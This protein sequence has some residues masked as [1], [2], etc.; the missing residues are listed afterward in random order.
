MT[1]VLTCGTSDSYSLFQIYKQR[2]QL[3]RF[4]P[5]VFHQFTAHL[6]HLPP[7]LCA[8]PLL[9]LV[10]QRSIGLPVPP[11]L[12]RLLPE[13]HKLN[14]TGSERGEAGRSQS[15]SSAEQNTSRLSLCEMPF[16]DPDIPPHSFGIHVDGGKKIFFILICQSRLA[17]SV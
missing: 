8:H 4:C 13:A 10:Q 17:E 5:P 7:A 12:N 11:L 2:Q 15:F 6:A 3:A 14:I 16:P 1:A 9:L